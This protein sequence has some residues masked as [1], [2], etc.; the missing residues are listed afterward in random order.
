[1]TTHRK[2][3]ILLALAFAASAAPAGADMMGTCAPEISRLCAGVTQGR[4]RVAACLVSHAGQLGAACQS[5]VNSVTT[6]TRSRLLLPAGVRTFLGSGTAP[7]VPG[8][9]HAD[10]ARLCAGVSPGNGPAL[11]CLYAHAG[12][13]D[14]ACSAEVDAALK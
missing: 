14:A 12:R 1:M 3:S 7:A 10:V 4:G 2:A 5:E 11:A 9:C 8:A 13:L 6:S